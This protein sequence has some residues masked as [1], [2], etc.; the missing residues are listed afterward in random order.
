MSARLDS[1]LSELNRRGT[2][3]VGPEL[4]EVVDLALAARERTSGRF[5]PTVH[6]ALVAAGYDRTFEEVSADTRGG[7]SRASAAPRCAG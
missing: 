4:L 3:P 6:D 5:D 2:L 7:N 1:E